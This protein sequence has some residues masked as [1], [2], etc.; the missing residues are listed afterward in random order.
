MSHEDRKW[1]QSGFGVSL[2]IS[3]WNVQEKIATNW[4]FNF[5]GNQ[6]QA[7][8]RAYSLVYNFFGQN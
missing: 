1:L 7:L 5:L 3:T 4:S 8:Q 6:H 2:E